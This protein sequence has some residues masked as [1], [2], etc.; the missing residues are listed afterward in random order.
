VEKENEAGK[1]DGNECTP[2]TKL[3][4]KDIFNYVKEQNLSNEEILGLVMELLGEL[5]NKHERKDKN[6][7][8]SDGRV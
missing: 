1:G 3:N 2:K 7:D 6:N 8:K 5:K 4:A